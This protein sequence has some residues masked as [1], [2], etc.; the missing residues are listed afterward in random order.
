MSPSLSLSQSKQCVALFAGFPT[1]LFI[2]CDDQQEFYDKIS[3]WKLF[4]NIHFMFYINRKWYVML[5]R[6]SLE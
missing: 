3:M 5:S 4:L 1:T 2:W 6:I